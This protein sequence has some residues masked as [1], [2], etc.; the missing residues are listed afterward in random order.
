MPKK[1]G[2]IQGFSRGVHE[3]PLQ[4]NDITIDYLRDENIASLNNFIRYGSY[5][6]GRD[7]R[8]TKNKSIADILFLSDDQC[9]ILL[10][11]IE[12]CRLNKDLIYG[13]PTQYEDDLFNKFLVS[14]QNAPNNLP[15]YFKV[16][17]LDEEIFYY[18]LIRSLLK[19]I[20]QYTAYCKN[21]GF[22]KLYTIGITDITTFNGK[23]QDISDIMSEYLIK[24]KLVYPFDLDKNDERKV[25]PMSKEK[26]IDE[27]TRE[28]MDKIHDEH[29][30]HCHKDD[31][32]R[33]CQYKFTHFKHHYQFYDSNFNVPTLIKRGQCH[34]E[35]SVYCDVEIQNLIDKMNDDDILF[36]PC[37]TPTT[38]EPLIFSHLKNIIIVGENDSSQTTTEDITKQIKSFRFVFDDSTV[39]L[40]N[41]YLDGS[42]IDGTDTVAI[43]VEGASTVTIEDCVITNYYRGVSASNSDGYSKA[44][45]EAIDSTFNCI[46]FNIYTDSPLGVT[47]RGCNFLK[48][49]HASI[50]VTHCNNN[51]TVVDIKNNNFLNNDSVSHTKTTE[52][53]D[54]PQCA[55]RL[56]NN[57]ISS[58]VGITAAYI[59]ENVFIN[60]PID[61]AIGI[62]YDEITNVDIRAEKN[63]GLYNIQNYAIEVE[64][65]PEPDP[66][67]QPEPQP[68]P[69]PVVEPQPS[70]DTPTD[71]TPTDNTDDTNVEFRI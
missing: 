55:I 59:T 32:E 9:T 13:C 65:Q 49:A 64:P 63:I 45:V 52:D 24:V 68:Q 29:D 10:N 34:K 70:D 8:L 25:Q 4:P 31:I 56:I 18:Q 1:S 51:R 54:L 66:E 36:L 57:K 11:F 27:I 7:H 71:T 47:T 38:Y 5:A 69:E 37:G 67:P 19:W 41:L 30:R 2:N 6:H 60:Q 23:L 12:L 21:N 39:L 50:Y 28:V 35:G 48:P 26:L 14:I 46:D 15:M 22:N 20:V 17:N 42:A 44:I 43:T 40:H 62:L 58:R 3:T 53:T 61:V 16:N 33:R